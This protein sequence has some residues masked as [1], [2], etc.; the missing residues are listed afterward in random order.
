MLRRFVWALA[1]VCGGLTTLTAAPGPAVTDPAKAGPDYAIQGEYLGTSDG[2]PT[3]AQVIALGKDEY[4]IVVYD[5]GLPG[6]GW[7]RGDR[8]MSV[9]GK[10]VDGKFDGTMKDGQKTIT[11]KFT[12]EALEIDGQGKAMTLKKYVRT[13]PTLGAKPPEGAVVLFDGKSKDEF[14]GG[15]LTDDGVLQT[16]PGG[17]LVSKK[18][19]TDFT[20]HLE[21]KT[22]YMP[23]A[24]GQGRGNSGL[25]LQNRYELQILDSFGLDG[26]DNECGGFYQA[27]KPAVNMC[28]PPLTWQTY[29]IDFTGAKFD[30]KGEKTADAVVTVKHNGVTIHDALKF[31]KVTPGGVGKE[32]P[33]RGPFQIQDHGNPVQLRNIWVVEKK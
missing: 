14:K 12:S 31:K 5:D 19:F 7:K 32:A 27:S 25:Y 4:D 10:L 23:E 1:L 2:K 9:K 16:N 18:E 29:D 13:S 21:F 11:F 33:G 30:D 24:R 15:S 8:K 26:A 17:S 22:P 3:G 28:L 6:E 20:I